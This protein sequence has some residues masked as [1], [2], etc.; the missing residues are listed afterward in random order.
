MIAS[1]L[2][3]GAW[4][5]PALWA[6]RWALF[7]GPLAGAGWLMKR[8]GDDRRRIAALFALLYGMGTIFVA[9]QVALAAGWWH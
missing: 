3:N 1:Y 5:E 9:H 4:P 7:L 2:P 6:L 8:E